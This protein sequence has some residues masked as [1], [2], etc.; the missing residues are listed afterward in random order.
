[1]EQLVA[2]SRGCPLCQWMSLRNCSLN[3]FSLFL[4]D[5]KVVVIQLD[6]RSLKQITW[7]I[8]MSAGAAGE[9]MSVCVFIYPKLG[10]HSLAQWIATTCQHHLTLP[11]DLLLTDSGHGAHEPG[12]NTVASS[13]DELHEWMN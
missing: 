12:A 9:R 13:P 2:V 1:M 5:R 8:T 7:I 4:V 10:P 3:S 6:E 11:E